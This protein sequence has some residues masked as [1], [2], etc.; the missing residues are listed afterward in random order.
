MIPKIPEKSKRFFENTGSIRFLYSRQDHLNG[1][2]TSGPSSWGAGAIMKAID[3]GFAGLVALDS[4]YR[5]LG[6]SPKFPVSYHKQIRYVTGYEKSGA[7]VDV[8][9][10][11]SEEGLLY[12]L[13]APSEEIRAHILLPKNVTVAKILVNGQEINATVSQVY[14]STYVDFNYKKVSG[15][16]LKIEIFLS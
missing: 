16:Q 8:R 3:E 10:Q 13:N 5:V 14:D 15:A 11:R 1:E 7:L 6:F 12:L 4:Q 9:Y 2:D